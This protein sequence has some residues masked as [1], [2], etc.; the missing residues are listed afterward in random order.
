MSTLTIHER[1][2]TAAGRMPAIGKDKTNKAQQFAYRSIEAIVREAR[3][4]FYDLGIAVTPEVLNWSSEE[5]ESKAG[6]KGYRVV[7]EMRYKLSCVGEESMDLFDRELVGSMMGEAIDY[8]DKATSKAG[9]MAWKYYLTD[10]LLVASGEEDADGESP[11]PAKP[12]KPAKPKK[13]PV[14]KLKEDLVKLHGEDPAADAWKVL[15]PGDSE[16]TKAPSAEELTAK[17]TG[18]IK[19]AIASIV[20]G[21]AADEEESESAEDGA[22]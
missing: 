15:F 5:V 12:A 7:V 4:L 8:G 2:A 19:L 22:S 10:V 1:L 21:P 3:P 20:D 16:E 9:Q 11:K 6:A 18:E 13:N 14:Q 17:R